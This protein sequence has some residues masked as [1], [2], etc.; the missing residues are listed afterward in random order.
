[1][2]APDC[3]TGFLTESIGSFRALKEQAERALAQADDDAFFARLDDGSN[4]L[5]VLVAHI[6]GN[7]MSRWT[8][9]LTTDGEKPARDRDGEFDLDPRLSRADLMG[10]WEEGWRAVFRATEA[11]TADDL[12]RVVSIRGE[13]H[14]VMQAILRQIRHYAYHV[15]QMVQLAR[16]YRGANWETLS[17]PRS[18]PRH[19]DGAPR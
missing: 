17:I 9:F 1:V 12:G 15:G 6:A 18:P 10:R 19:Y 5:A 4:S 2:T 13:V 16:H 7:A 3:G 8:D 11:L 14:T